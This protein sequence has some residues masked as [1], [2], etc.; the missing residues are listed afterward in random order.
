MTDELRRQL[1]ASEA[2]VAE[3]EAKLQALETRQS[4]QVLEQHILNEVLHIS[5]TMLVVLDRDGRIVRFNAACERA[6]GYSKDEMLGEYIFERLIPDRARAG[7]RAVFDTLVAGQFPNTYENPWVAKD[8]HEVPIAWSNS[9]TVD[10]Q[11]AVNHLVAT[12]IDISR[13]DRSTKTLKATE[14]L[15][16]SNIIGLVVSDGEGRLLEA[17]DAFL[18]M[19]GYSSSELHTPGLRWDDMTP[20]EFKDQDTKALQELESQDIAAPFEKEYLRKDGSRVPVFLSL[21]GLPT[22]PKTYTGIVLDLSARKKKEKERRRLETQVQHAQKLESLGVLA[23]GIAHDFNNLLVG[24]LGNADLA[25]MDL[26]PVSPVRSHLADIRT[27]AKRAA[28]LVR[29]MLAYSGKG[30]FVIE[31]L[32]LGDLVQEMSHLLEVSISKSA[33]VKYH[34]AKNIP[35]VEADATQLRQVVMNLITNAS[36]AIGDKSGVISIRTGAM[37]CDPKYLASTYYDV[38]ASPGY[39]VYVEVSDTGCGMDEEVCRRLF[40][41]FFTTKFTGR[42]LG[43]AAVLGIIRG[44]GGAIK[45]Y[46]EV[47]VGTTIKILLPAAEGPISPPRP[48]ANQLDWKAEGTI[49]LVDDEETVLAVGK[50][51][52]ERI[53]F[54]VLIADDGMEALRVFQRYPEISCVLLDLTMPHLDGEQTMRELRRIR[55]DIVVVLTSGYSEFEIKERFPGKDVPHFIQKPYRYKDL[56]DVLRLATESGT[57]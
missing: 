18:S 55:S 7:V 52:L 11:G 4:E 34:C 47:G 3:L 14:A 28:E 30:Q 36:E 33:V 21:A 23:G 54:K 20:P 1:E 15:L 57:R 17:N 10:S 35:P 19:V 37:D 50:R 5:E 43:M 53:G 38:E 45:L 31:R 2:R 44:H 41:P 27:T 32:Q 51:M 12:G 9:C 25:L 29:Q 16:Q 26:S 22:A 6:T 48:E 40:D 42:G 49:L 46:S 24:I 8:G 39:F 56:Q 13:L